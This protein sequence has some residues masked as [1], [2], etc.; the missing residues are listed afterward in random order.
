LA[1]PL[2]GFDAIHLASERVIQEKLPEDF[3]FACFDVGLARAAQAE[4][5]NTFPRIKR[6]E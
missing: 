2:R 3:V 6:D 5:F 4:G 1:H